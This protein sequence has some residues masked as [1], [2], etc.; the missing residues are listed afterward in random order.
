ML[1]L[2]RKFPLL[3]MKCSGP[4]NFH[5][6]LPS[7]FHWASRV[8]ACPPGLCCHTDDSRQDW[9]KPCLRNIPGTEILSR[10]IAMPK[11]RCMPVCQAQSRRGVG[12]FR[13]LGLGQNRGVCGDS[14]CIL[15]QPAQC[16]S[17]LPADSAMLAAVGGSL[18]FCREYKKHRQVPKCLTPKESGWTA[19]P[20]AKSDLKCHDLC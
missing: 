7:H 11:P 12:I 9:Q 5:T 19:W 15:G 17:G 18:V 4:P 13:L 14:P 20:W 1:I 2:A 3:Q 16:A 8:S 6:S 10:G